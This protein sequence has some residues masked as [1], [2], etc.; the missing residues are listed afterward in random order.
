ME[1]M[2]L[3]ERPRTCNKTQHIEMSA[4]EPS[5]EKDFLAD[6]VEHPRPTTIYLTSGVALEGVIAWFDT[7][8]SA[9]LHG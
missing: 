3:A 9:T 4:N 2:R 8:L 5:S 7:P 6:L 1:F